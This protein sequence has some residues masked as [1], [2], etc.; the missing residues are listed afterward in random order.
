MARKRSKALGTAQSMT[1]AMPI[2]DVLDASAFGIE[3]IVTTPSSMPKPTLQMPFASGAAPTLQLS[4][5]GDV[6]AKVHDDNVLANQMADGREAAAKS[7]WAVN[8]ADGDVVSGLRKTY[9][10]ID[11]DNEVRVAE[12]AERDAGRR[13]ARSRIEAN[14]KANKSSGF[15]N[16]VRQ[17]DAADE[18]DAQEAK[19]KRASDAKARLEES[20]KI[21]A[22]SGF[23]RA[24]K[25]FQAAD[26]KDRLAAERDHKYETAAQDAY[27]DEI[28]QPLAAQKKAAKEKAAADKAEAIKKADG[29]DEYY[30]QLADAEQAAEAKAGME[31]AKQERAHQQKLSAEVASRAKAEE[32][33]KTHADAAQ[34]RINDAT[35]VS[36]GGRHLSSQET[37]DIVGLFT[38]QGQYA[39]GKGYNTE[40]DAVLGEKIRKARK[41][42]M[43]KNGGKAGDFDEALRKN[44]GMILGENDKGLLGD[45]NTFLERKDL[46]QQNVT[47]YKKDLQNRLKKIEDRTKGKSF[48]DLRYQE[49]EK[50][51]LSK[52]ETEAIQKKTTG[53]H[54]LGARLRD[55]LGKAVNK[56]TFGHAHVRTNRA[57]EIRNTEAQKVVNQRRG[58]IK[59]QI[60]SAGQQLQ[61][62]KEYRED[63]IEGGR[64][65]NAIRKYRRNEVKQQKK[66]TAAKKAGKLN[67]GW[68]AKAGAV[69][70]LLALGAVLGNM[71]GNHGEQSN[72]QLYNPN[73]QPQYA[74]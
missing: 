51:F 70:G 15:G 42:F 33:A 59:N 39:S 52:A 14:D 69:G 44:P 29:I 24:Q 66:A 38:R 36:N 7:R 8:Q 10:Q 32:V 5:F 19:E 21:N 74:N 17:E 40:N 49:G 1:P 23:S 58:A 28:N 31:A 37:N 30:A 27:D 71:M 68:K 53:M 26:E 3:D 60:K 43:E 12:D 55:N 13:K 41:D 64:S 48:E 72:A 25:D 16:F 54:G 73:P 61:D 47:V 22:A 56:A 45:L 34:K 62:I 9:A 65:R 57:E 67:L 2:A 6:S 11:S 35:G 63:A 46:A 18:R 4:S 50:G 20:R